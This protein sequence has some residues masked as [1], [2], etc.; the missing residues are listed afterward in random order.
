MGLK[1]PRLPLPLFA[2]A[3]APASAAAATTAASAPEA[4]PTPANASA[5]PAALLAALGAWRQ[6]K[7]LWAAG[8]G[9]L[10]LSVLLMMWMQPAAFGL[11]GSGRASAMA[12]AASSPASAAE[13]GDAPRSPQAAQTV[14]TSVSSTPAAPTPIEVPDEAAQAQA[15]LREMPPQQ[16]VIQHGAHASYEKAQ[17]MLKAYASLR[18]ARIVAV[19][20]P[21]E[22][23]AYFVVV[24]GPFEG[25]GKAYE[26]FGR[27]DLP[28]TSWVRT[29]GSLQQQLQPTAAAKE[30]R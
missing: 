22:K 6:R 4:A 29:A 15:W 28:N 16:F 25:A 21:G 10:A 5:R 1:L 18:E 12:S 2:A 11:R 19:W 9:A 30:N 7:P 20:R 13:S 14:V 24:S 3:A 8:A 23:L 26:R 17:Q 27:K